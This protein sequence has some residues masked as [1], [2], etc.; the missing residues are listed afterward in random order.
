M[1]KRRR[2]QG[3]GAIFKTTKNGKRVWCAEMATGELTAKGWRARRRAY[4]ATQAEA[5]AELA[6][7]QKE[8]KEAK[9]AKEVK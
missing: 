2:V 5:R 1:S 8:A 7:W 3:E 4:R 9:E 6:V